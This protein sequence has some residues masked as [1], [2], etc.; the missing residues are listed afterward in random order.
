MIKIDLITGFLGSGKTTFIKKYASYLLKKGMNIGILKQHHIH[1]YC[2]EIIFQDIY[3]ALTPEQQAVVDECGHT[4]FVCPA[5]F[6]LIIAGTVDITL[7]LYGFLAA[8]IN[9]SLLL[10]CQCIVNI[11]VDTEEQTVIDG[12]P[13]GAVWLL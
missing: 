13:H 11:L 7:I 10:R 2:P 4:V 9:N 5:C 8:L 6:D 12:I 3:D 1:I